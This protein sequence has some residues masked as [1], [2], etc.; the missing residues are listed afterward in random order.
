MLPQGDFAR[1]AQ[2]DS[3]GHDAQGAED[4]AHGG[5]GDAVASFQ[6]GDLRPLHAN[7]LAKFLLRQVLLDARFPY[8]LSQAAGVQGFVNIAF[9]GVALWSADLAEMFVK[10]IVQRGEF[11][12]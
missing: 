3:G 1:N 10:H 8:G 4:L 12:L 9:K 5:D 7:A 11:H 6:T 2:I